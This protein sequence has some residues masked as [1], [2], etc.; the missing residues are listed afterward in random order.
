MQLHCRPAFSSS[1]AFE[2]WRQGSSYYVSVLH[3]WQPLPLLRAKYQIPGHEV[4]GMASAAAAAAAAAADAS[5]GCRLT[6]SGST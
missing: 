4:D 3:N 6:S 1:I 5:T 2:L